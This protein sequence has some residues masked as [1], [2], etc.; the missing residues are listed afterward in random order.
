MSPQVILINYLGCLYQFIE[1]LVETIL[2]QLQKQTI[3][4]GL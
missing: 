4:S 2:E 3:G 1:L